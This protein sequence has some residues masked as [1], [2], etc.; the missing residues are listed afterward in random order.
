MI[1]LCQLLML[2]FII[3]FTGLAL[4]R[5]L[6]LLPQQLYCEQLFGVRAGRRNS[7]QC[8]CANNCEYSGLGWRVAQ[9]DYPD[10]T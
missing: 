9:P 4:S 6:L 7:L 1:T 2:T 8:V 3:F 5:Q 10:L